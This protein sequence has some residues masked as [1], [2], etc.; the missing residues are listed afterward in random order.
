MPMP[1]SVTR[2]RRNGVEF[3]SNVDRVKYTIQ[4]LARAALKDVAKLIR[5]RILDKARKMPGMR[6]GKR[7]PN[8]FQYWV[9][10]RESDLQIGV[11]HDTWYGVDQELGTNGQPAR[12]IIRD[13][14]YENI[15]QIRII[16]GKYLSSIESENRA[17][18]LIDEEEEIGNEDN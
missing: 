1:R 8:A 10:K 4:E 12:H 16:Q 15:D 13:T 18:G 17:R 5:R 2:V 9:R 3:T 14:V 7:I 6:K 11:K